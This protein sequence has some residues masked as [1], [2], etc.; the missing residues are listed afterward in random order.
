MR[1]IE[2]KVDK[3]Y[4]PSNVVGSPKETEPTKYFPTLRLEHQFFPEV[5]NW[6]V[7]AE[8]EVTLKIKMTGVSIS[9]Y[10]NDSEFEIV[11][12]EG[13]KEEKGEKEGKE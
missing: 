13:E 3:M 7:G 2:P 6:K 11:G 4:G 1:K 5:K 10:Q 9:K 12:F 8:Y